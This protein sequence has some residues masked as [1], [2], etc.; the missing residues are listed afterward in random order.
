ML[1]AAGARMLVR[2]VLT[3]SIFG[4]AGSLLGGCG[5]SVHSDLTLDGKRFGPH[6]C[7]SGQDEEFNGVDLRDASGT[8]IRIA[9]NVDHSVSIVIF[10][11]DVRPESM[12]GC[13][14]V[15]L[16]KSSYDKKGRYKVDGT[17]QIDCVSSRHQVKGR[18]E[19]DDCAH[20]W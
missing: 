4:L 10:E 16:S 2:S 12:V 19:V 8:F 11:P 18:V 13:S 7:R 14:V 17:A 15:H 5:S 1:L 20:G 9:S 6:E 3:A